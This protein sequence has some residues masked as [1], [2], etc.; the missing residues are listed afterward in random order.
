VSASPG[1]TS[2]SPADW[3]DALR[4]ELNRRIA[5]IDTYPE[6]AFGRIGLVEALAMTA[7]F[8]LL[9]AAMVWLCR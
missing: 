7:L 2:E 1:E 4:G 5:Q 6:D 3:D 8:V 9:P